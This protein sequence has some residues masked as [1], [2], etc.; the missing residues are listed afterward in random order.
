MSTHLTDVLSQAYDAV[1]YASHPFPQSAPEN[2]E[3]IAHLFGLAACPPAQARVLELGCASGGN[4]IPLAARYPQLQAVGIDL[5]TVQVQQG[6]QDITRAGLGNVTLKNMNLEE[7]DASLGQFDYII[8]HGVYS[9]VP[10]AVQTAILRIASKNLAPDGVVYISYNT[11]PG[12]KAREIVRD[13]MLLRGADRATPAE[14]LSYARGMVEFLHDMARDGSVL[15]KTLEETMPTIQNSQDYYLI[16]E[17]LEA[18][19][20]PC[21][22]KDF[23]AAAGA[24]GLAY[25]GDAEPST[26]FVSNY[27]DKVATPLLQECGS[28]QVMLEQYLDFIVNRQFRQTVLVKQARASSVRYQLDHARIR[29]MDYAA[30][31]QCEQPITLDGGP[32]QCKAWRNVDVT[33]NTPVSKALALTLNAH[34]PGTI[35]QEALLDAVCQA[36]G[37]PRSTVEPELLDM[38]NHLI[39]T[40][41]VRYR[42]TAVRAPA[43]LSTQP[44]LSAQ[45]RQALVP[46]QPAPT[47]LCNAWHEDVALGI[48]Q[49][50]ILPLLDGHHGTEALIAHLLQEAQAG[51]IRFLRQGATVT[52]AADMERSAREQL[53]AALE[54]LRQ[55][56][57]L[58][59]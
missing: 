45:Y 31:F 40:G 44:Q 54:G 47:T 37:Q 12:W 58:A 51:R 48:V 25:L 41:G 20:A 18:C 38:L 14:Q 3:A 50:S 23:V 10:P 55:Q 5:S 27:G 9:W 17:F 4:L 49:Q 22:L 56:A 13:A 33:L 57:L 21:Y 46:S 30:F 15:K 26:M 29:H 19:N 39:I 7:V 53:P 28:S 24:Q 11:Y 34:Y 6:Q 43:A 16:H 2:L 32:V 59:S 52:D 36:V 42:R 8:C 1:P 35:T